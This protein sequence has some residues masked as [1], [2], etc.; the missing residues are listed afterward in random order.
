[1]AGWQTEGTN[2]LNR[3]SA[4]LGINRVVRKRTAEESLKLCELDEPSSN[5]SP[6]WGLL[7]RVHAGGRTAFI[8]PGVTSH[9]FMHPQPYGSPDDFQFLVNALHEASI[10]QLSIGCPP[11]SRDE[12]ALA[13]F[14]GPPL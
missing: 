9:W 13:K 5:I 1:M 8:H 6:A 7:R 12:W 4:F 11:F 10:R 14:D 3:R 2:T